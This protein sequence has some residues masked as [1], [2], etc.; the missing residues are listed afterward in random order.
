MHEIHANKGVNLEIID[1]GDGVGNMSIGNFDRER[2][3][4]GRA[5]SKTICPAKVG[6]RGNLSS[7]GKCP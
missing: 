6:L 3:S 4:P 7:M 5:E 1:E 2:V